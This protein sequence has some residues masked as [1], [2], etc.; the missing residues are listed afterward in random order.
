MQK[1]KSTYFI[2][3]FQRYILAILLLASVLPL[4]SQYGTKAKVTNVDF[5]LYNDIIVVNYDLIEAKPWDLFDIKFEVY[6]SA[7]YKIEAQSLEGKL[8]DVKRG[9]HQEIKWYLGQDYNNFED[10]IYIQLTAMHKNHKNINRVTRIEA[11]GKSMIFPG[12]GSAQLTLKKKYYSH[13]IVTYGL[14][15]SSYYLQKLYEREEEKA[16]NEDDFSK[17]HD[18]H[19]NADY[20]KNATY[21]TLGLAGLMYIIEIN[22]VLFTPNIS[23][24]IKFDYQIGSV[25]NK[26]VPMLSLK[27][28][29]DR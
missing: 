22:R 4:F 7:G 21:V 18:Y 15:G 19:Q 1:G 26:T 6:N 10:N 16:D 8:N 28:N 11:L 2:N 29:I 25:Q 5:K 3:K 14:I 17:R 23:K 9:K 27:M 13:G 20:Y 24:K 12:W